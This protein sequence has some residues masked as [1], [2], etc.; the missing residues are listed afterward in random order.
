MPKQDL[1]Q[2]NVGVL[3][4]QVCGEAVPQRVWRHSL[5]DL[6]HMAAA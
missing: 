2:A 3:L 4:Q 5:L 6:G 1:D